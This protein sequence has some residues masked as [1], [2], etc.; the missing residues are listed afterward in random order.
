MSKSPPAPVRL[1]LPRPSRDG[2]AAPGDQLAAQL[3]YRILTGDLRPGDRLPPVRRLA[4]FL[5]VN[6]NTVARVY[7]RLEAEGHLV[8]RGRRGTFVRRASPLS[9][10]VNALIARL[11]REA[12]RRRLS[13]ADLQTLLVMR[14]RPRT[15]RLRVGFVECNTVDLTYF[16]RLLEREVGAPIRPIL[17]RRLPVAARGCD[18]LVT[19][20]FHIEEVQRKVPSREVLGLVALPDFRTL[21]EVARLSRTA[22]VALVCATDEGVRSKARSLRAVGLR[23]PRLVTATLGERTRLRAALG[24]AEVLLASPKVLERLRGTIPPRVRVIP[25]AS[26]LSDGAVALLRRRLAEAPA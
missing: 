20:F 3:R 18:L 22:R 5:R 12:A 7:R 23:R 4:A 25:F 19:T 24:R 10:E 14:A 15:A 6:R 2:R 17:L 11:L 13:P 9:P 16:R 1:T 26:V 21:E 8:T